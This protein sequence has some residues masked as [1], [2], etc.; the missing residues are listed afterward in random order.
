MRNITDVGGSSPVAERG[1]TA[2]GINERNTRLSVMSRWHMYRK[3][4]TCDCPS[5]VDRR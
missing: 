2:R 4:Y 5:F 1:F 3:P